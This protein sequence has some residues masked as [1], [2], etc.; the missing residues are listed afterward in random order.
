M[1]AMHRTRLTGLPDERGDGVAAEWVGDEQMP[2]ITI[3]PA[4]TL[5][6]R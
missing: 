2:P 1:M 4:F 3:Q 5:G 6:V